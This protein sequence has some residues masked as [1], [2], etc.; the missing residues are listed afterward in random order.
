MLVEINSEAANGTLHAAAGQAVSSGAHRV[1]LLI[2]LLDQI[3]YYADREPFATPHA[4]KVCETLEMY[5]RRLVAA[6]DL[7]KCQDS[8]RD[9][10][11]EIE[12]HFDQNK[13]RGISLILWECLEKAT[14]CP[15][16]IRQCHLI[17]PAESFRDLIVLILSARPGFEHRISF[18]LAS[19]VFIEA[20]SRSGRQ[21]TV[22][23][24][25]PGT[26]TAFKA[27]LAKE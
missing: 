16:T 21:V 11:L 25:R 1:K 2:E 27:H 26:P 22:D 7:K 5:A 15:Y 9:R 23:I 19:K 13:E 18:P 8:I 24:V 6:L 17:A 14:L 3:E 12:L 20:A 4:T 10:I